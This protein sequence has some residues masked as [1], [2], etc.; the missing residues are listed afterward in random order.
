MV[1]A[2]FEANPLNRVIGQPNLGSICQM[3]DQLADI[4]SSFLTTQWGGNHRYLPLVLV[5]TKMPLVAKDNNLTCA[6]ITKT[7]CTSAKITKDSSPKEIITFQDKKKILWQE[8][9]FQQ[10][11]HCISFT[12]LRGT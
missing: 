9:K 5:Q 2:I 1:G 3:V 4:V 8:Y 12:I 7:D 11:I 6:F 10:A